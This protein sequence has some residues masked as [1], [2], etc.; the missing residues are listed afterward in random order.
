MPASVGDVAG[1]EDEADVFRIGIRHDVFDFV[2]ALKLAAKV[3]VGSE[4]H[5]FFFIDAP[6]EDLERFSDVL[7][8][9][10]SGASRPPGTQ[11]GFLMPGPEAFAEA[12]HPEMILDHGL[13]TRGI[14]KMRIASACTAGDGDEAN[15]NPVDLPL[16]RGRVVGIVIVERGGERFHPAEADFMSLGEAFERIAFPAAS[17]IGGVTDPVARVCAE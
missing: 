6:A 12:D 4:A 10:L 7:E 5:A 13:A 3:S 17:G 1:V 2:L 15:T 11:V 16:E 14:F 9:L 8:V